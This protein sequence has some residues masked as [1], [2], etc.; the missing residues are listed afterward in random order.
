VCLPGFTILNL[1]LGPGRCLGVA[2]G[3]GLQSL[4]LPAL[5]GLYCLCC[6]G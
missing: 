6:V 1:T 4:A 2:Q 5:L 3:I